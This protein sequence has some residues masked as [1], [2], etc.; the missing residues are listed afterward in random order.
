MELYENII[1]KIIYMVGV[2]NFH[3]L[4]EERK[5]EIIKIIMSMAA[6]FP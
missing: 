5:G 6:S 4:Y 2:H 1:L 3:Y